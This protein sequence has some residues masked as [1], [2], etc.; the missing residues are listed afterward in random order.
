MAILLW[1][2]L[3]GNGRA[4][5]SKRR[6]G[7]AGRGNAALARGRALEQRFAFALGMRLLAKAPQQLPP[8]AARVFFEHQRCVRI[9]D[10]PEAA[11]QFALQLA[12]QPADETGEVTRVVRRL[13]DDAV[14]AAAV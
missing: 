6:A 7:R 3:L 8:H 13:L 5:F 11:L 2:P 12:R 4:G 9:G 14:D 10:V 1:L